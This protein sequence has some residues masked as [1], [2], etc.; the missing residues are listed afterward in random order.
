MDFKL[1]ERQLGVR[2]AIR[3]LLT[4]DVGDAGLLPLLL[5]RGLIRR[6]EC[7]EEVLEAT[8]V[9]EELS[10]AGRLVPAGVQALVAPL[11]AEIPDEPVAIQREGAVTPVRFAATA[12]LLIVLGKDRA[13]VYRVDPRSARPVAS[14]YVYPVACPASAGKPLTILPA[15]KVQRRWQLAI[16]AEIV[17]AMDAAM[18]KLISYLTERRQFGQRLAS[19]QALQHRL[20][21]LAVSVECSRILLREAAWRDSDE[22]AASA[23]C[24]AVGAARQVC[25]EAHQL[26]G[27]RGFTHEFGL[28]HA[29]LRL[30]LLSLEAGGGSQHAV[31]SAM[32]RWSPAPQLVGCDIDDRNAASSLKVPV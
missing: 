25:L 6:L 5:K 32:E 30:Q 24:Y 14:N 12:P 31:V 9:T 20:S 23:A 18:E 17:G 21:E 26:S 4:G 13:S 8:I 29:T 3:G 1:N 11:L 19:F 2:D 15:D 10:R 22:L 16:S 28:Y 7:G 27:A